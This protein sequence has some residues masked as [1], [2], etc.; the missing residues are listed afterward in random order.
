MDSHGM[1]WETALKSVVANTGHERYRVLCSDAWPDHEAYRALMIQMAGG[2]SKPLEYP[3][4]SQ[5]AKNAVRAVGSVFASAIHGEP[6]T[7][8]QEE[9]D[10]RLAICHACQHFD[11]QQ[12]RCRLCGCF[13]N[14]KARLA[15]QHCPDDPPRW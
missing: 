7:V 2:E 11:S 1:S 6:V 10:R 9:Q 12:H 8:P 15:G 3:S 5:Q 4:L 13:A 14:L